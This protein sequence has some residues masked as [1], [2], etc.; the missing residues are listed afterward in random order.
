M[1]DPN[2]ENGQR[3]RVNGEQVR[4]LYPEAATIDNLAAARIWAFEQ[5]SACKKGYDPRDQ[6]RAEAR[7]V[8]IVT[9]QSNRRIFE[10][11]MDRSCAAKRY[12]RS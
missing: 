10:N 11:V 2:F 12:T 7:A 3:T 6:K 1:S 5:I 8:R 4:L 9:E